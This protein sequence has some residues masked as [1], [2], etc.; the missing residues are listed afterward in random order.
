MK[1]DKI[2][3]VTTHELGGMYKYHVYFSGRPEGHPMIM[4]ELTANLLAISNDIKVIQ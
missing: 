2:M 3:K 4:A 1:I